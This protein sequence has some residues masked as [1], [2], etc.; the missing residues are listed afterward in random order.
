MNFTVVGMEQIQ[1]LANLAFFNIR[2]KFSK[3]CDKEK[4]HIAFGDGS[5]GFS[6]F[7]PYDIIYVK[8]LLYFYYYFI[9]FPKIYIYFSN[10]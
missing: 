7:A 9:L 2:K 6:K 3:L 8:L 10:L 5:K 1:V 4:V